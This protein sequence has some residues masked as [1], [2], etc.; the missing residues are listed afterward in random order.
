MKEIEIVSEHGQRYIDDI[1]RIKNILLHRGYNAT[2]T[3]SEQL[4]DRYSDSM[5]AGWMTLPENDEEVFECI[6]Y[7]IN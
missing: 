7:Y 6:S 4:W 3:N 5:A 2:L 1:R